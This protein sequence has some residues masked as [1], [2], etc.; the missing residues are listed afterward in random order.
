MQNGILGGIPYHSWSSPTHHF[1]DGFTLFR[2]IAMSWAIL[3]S[4]LVFT[5]LAMIQ[6]ATSEVCQMLIFLWHC[7][8]IKMMSAI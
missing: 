2:C 8:Q 3:A 5:I 1:T 7:V 6:T 4:S